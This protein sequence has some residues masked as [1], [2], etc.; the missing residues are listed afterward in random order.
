MPDGTQDLMVHCNCSE[1]PKPCRHI[2]ATY[3][4][5]A[6]AFDQDPFLLCRWRG[7]NRE[8]LLERV[9]ALRAALVP[10]APEPE[11]FYLS[12]LE[13]EPQP[14][15]AAD[16]ASSQ[17]GSAAQ[18]DFYLQV[19]EHCVAD[20]EQLNLVILTEWHRLNQEVLRV[21]SC[22]QD[23]EGRKLV[24]AQMFAAASDLLGEPNDLDMTPAIQEG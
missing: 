14:A 9:A 8:Q 4:T 23:L 22:I 21:Q 6:E 18:R 20:V 11:P 5:L 13:A 15:A 10:P 1:M 16:P 3:Y 24:A 2:A 7:R 12:G 19:R 17:P